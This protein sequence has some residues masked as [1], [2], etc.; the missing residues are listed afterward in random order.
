VSAESYQE[1]NRPNC[2][3]FGPAEGRNIEGEIVRLAAETSADDYGSA[4]KR[5]HEISGGGDSCKT[6]HCPE[7]P[8]AS[9]ICTLKNGLVKNMFPGDRLRS[10]WKADAVSNP[11]TLRDS[12]RA[13]PKTGSAPPNRLPDAAFGAIG[14]AT[15]CTGCKP[16]SPTRYALP[17][18]V[19]PLTGGRFNSKIHL[20][21]QAF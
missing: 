4:L 15:S 21:R 19:N 11:L 1:V 10:L 3:K 12:V 8:F 18:S 16:C 9:G 13:A 5:A 20:V 6:L 2:S 7:H 14:Y 17:D